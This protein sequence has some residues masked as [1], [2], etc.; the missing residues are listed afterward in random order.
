MAKP[1]PTR[2]SKLLIQEEPLQVLPGLAVALGL[3][4]AIILQQLHYWLGRKSHTREGEEWHYN[5]YEDWKKQ[6]P[7]WSVSTIKRAILHLQ[8]VGVVIA[9]NFNNSPIDKTK[10]YRINYQKLNAL[11]DLSTAQNEPSTDHIEPS[12][13]Q[14]EPSTDH[15]EPSWGQDEPTM[16]QNDPTNT[17][18]LHSETTKPKIPPI[19]PHGGKQG[20]SQAFLTFWVAYPVKKQKDRA[21]GMWQKKRCEHA[22][23]A[24][25]ASIEDHRAN[26]SQWQRGYIPYPSTFL[27]DGSWKDELSPHAHESNGYL[28]GDK[29]H[30]ALEEHAHG[31]A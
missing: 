1:T 15:I 24:I 20:Y 8:E 10:W 28:I 14:N 13:A 30:R 2:T 27:N 22:L 3:N 31:Q 17:K 9:A 19:S 7:F 25:L 4:E 29:L 23:D 18:R 16:A 26:D 5:T 12:T 21:W 11:G 6:F